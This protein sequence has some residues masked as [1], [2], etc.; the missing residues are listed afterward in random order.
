MIIPAYNRQE[1]IQK[2]VESVLNQT[3]KDFELIIID[4]GSTDD[5]KKIIQSFKDKR[6]RY[7]Y[8]FNRGPAV[9]RNKGIK[10][11]SASYIAFLDSDDAWAPE[12]LAIQMK[13]MK[14]HPEYLI[15]HTEEEWYKGKRR[16]KHLNIHKKKQDNI[17]KRSLQLCSIS[18]STVI[19]KKELTVRIGLFD[20]DLEV[21]EDY[22]YWLRVTAQYPVLLIDQALTIKQGGHYDQQSQKYYGLDKFRIYAIEK[23]IKSKSLDTEQLIPTYKEFHK[24]CRI[25]GH[26]CIKYGKNTEGENHLELSEK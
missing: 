13:A 16:I 3:F 21:C 2:A 7:Y 9:A 10:K 8:H 4:D 24:K 25:Y 23:L 26:S 15:S 14:E 1:F 18:M 17:F 12:K 19:I 22:D 6:I 11:S 5:T 20:P